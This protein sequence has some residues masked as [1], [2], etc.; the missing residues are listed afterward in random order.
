[1]NAD[2]SIEKEI[3]PSLLEENDVPIHELRSHPKTPPLQR[4]DHPI[5]MAK[6][7]EPSV[8][9]HSNDHIAVICQMYASVWG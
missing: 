3:L 4:N 8:R 7:D 1:M 5:F 6:T 2:K 9:Y